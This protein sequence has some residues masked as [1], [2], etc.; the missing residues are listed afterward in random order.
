MYKYNESTPDIGGISFLLFHFLNVIEC[1]TIGHLSFF[2][3]HLDNNIMYVLCHA[4][5]ITKIYF[6]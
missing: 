3:D 5:R 1:L 4:S 6:K 2:H